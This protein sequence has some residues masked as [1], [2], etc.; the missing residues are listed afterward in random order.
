MSR[1]YKEKELRSI[2]GKIKT[3]KKESGFFIKNIW[4][5]VGFGIFLA[6]TYSSEDYLSGH[7]SVM[8]SA[9]MDYYGLVIL[10]ASIYTL[11]SFLAHFIWQYQDKI[12][13][14]RL[15]KRKNQLE[16]ELSI[17]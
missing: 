13:I 12:K 10:T 15:E 6:P 8:N 16:K 17:K 1:H 14:N 11:F 5:V 9:A 3:T 2:Q 4:K 7:R